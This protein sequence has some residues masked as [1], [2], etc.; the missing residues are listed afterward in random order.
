AMRI[1]RWTRSA[2]VICAAAV[3]ALAG[4]GTAAAAS[5]YP[6]NSTIVAGIAD[7]LADPAAAPPGVNIAGCTL[8]QAH[9]R[10]LILIDGTFANM[11]D[12]W[13]GLGSTLANEGYCVYSTPIG[14][15]PHSVIQTTGSVASSAQQVSALVQRVLGETGARQVDLLGHSQGGMIAEYYAK[16]L[17]GA[18]KVHTLIG[19][20]PTTH[21]T[22]LD[23]IATLAK[24]FPG[25]KKLIGNACQACTDQLPDSSVITALDN[26]PIAQPGIDYTIIE[27][28]YEF[29]VT[30]VGSSFIHESGVHNEY[31]QDYCP[32]DVVDHV[33]LT[34]D[35]AVTSLVSNALSPSTANQVRC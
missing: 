2:L 18:S 19:L 24:I 4:A 33:N 12:D 21:G 14:A 34:Y 10:P 30:P 15:N 31:V 35:R 6:V 17:G 25:A 27:T 26:G 29:V 9:P 13:S 28:R 32:F 7:S 1:P 8:T 11:T 20:S 3:T 22:T 5:H 16:V 23:G